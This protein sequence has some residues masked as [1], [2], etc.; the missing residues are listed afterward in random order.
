MAETISLSPAEPRAPLSRE[1]V[2][3]TAVELA[4]EGGIDSLTMRKLA[5][6]LGVEAMSLYHYVA[7]KDDILQGILD[8][9]L[10]EVEHPPAGD[11]WK[12]ALRRGA[13]SMHDALVRH[14]WAANLMSSAP[15]V[16][17]AR[18]AF[19][20]W[21]LGT[22]REAGFS[23]E[24]TDHAYHALDSHITGYTLWVGSMPFTSDEELASLASSFLSTLP[25]D[26]PYM[27]EH[28]EQHLL[29]LR[30]LPEDQVSDFEFGL[31][32]ILDGLERILARALSRHLLAICNVVGRLADADPSPV[33]GR[34]SPNPQSGDPIMCLTC[35]CMDAHLEMGEANITYED[36][37]R[38]ADEN[39][40][41][42]AETLDIMERTKAKDRQE[43][44][45]GVRGGVRR[46]GADR[47]ELTGRLDAALEV[48]EPRR[49]AGPGHQLQRR[50]RKSRGESAGGV[51]TTERVVLA[52]EH[53]RRRPDRRDHRLRQEH[54]V[55]PAERPDQRPAHRDLVAHR[56]GVPD[57][58]QVAGDVLG[59]DPAVVD[60]R[61]VAEAG[62]TAA[63]SSA[64]SAGSPPRGGRGPAAPSAA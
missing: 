24:M 29:A 14:R 41:S 49:V 55:E 42:V 54:R 47:Q 32:L 61:A 40:R 48:V 3:R 15:N 50:I 10:S 36:I 16:S 58:G 63:G 6:A 62:G 57:E 28:V 9:A 20:E 59:R 27:A 13:I 22:L 12:G 4:D 51:A 56:V 5:Q 25:A 11:D 31:D 35:G 45:A 23:A 7:K 1:R 39:G 38:A 2:L 17:P 37:K 44:A 43:H 30:R 46:P 52:P 34:W 26:Y 60:R 64:R 8:L 21:S 19:M 33:I 18:L 53:E